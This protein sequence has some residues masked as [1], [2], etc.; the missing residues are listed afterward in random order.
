ELAD[1]VFVNEREADA[2]GAEPWGD[3]LRADAT[4]VVTLGSDGA[5]VRTPDTTHR[6]DGFAI[7][8]LDTTGAGDA[9]ASG[10]LA[11]R[12][13]AVDGTAAADALD[14]TAT[15]DSSARSFD[16]T[17]AVANACGAI[18]SREL[19]ARATLDWDRVAE[20]V[21]DGRQT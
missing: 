21:R 3:T 17:L 7:E 15:V 9:F 6:H 19:G 11:A 18:A 14:A 5:E 4:L 20:I 2:L 13:G 10:F 16:D 12:G 1:L 8:P